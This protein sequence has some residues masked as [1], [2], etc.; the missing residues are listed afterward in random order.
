MSDFL[1]SDD[2]IPR[3][4]CS[5]HRELV[6]EKLKATNQRVDGILDEIKGVRELQK[7]IWYTLIFIAFGVC[8]T[9]AGVIM[10]RGFDF[11]WIVK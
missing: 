11:G 8:F 3:T 4:E 2:Y 6:E 5:L 10:G 9:L 7:N 1:N